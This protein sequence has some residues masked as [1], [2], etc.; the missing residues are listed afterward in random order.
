MGRERW[1]GDRKGRKRK[2]KKKGRRSSHGSVG[3]STHGEERRKG[4]E[5]KGLAQQK[6]EVGSDF[7]TRKKGKSV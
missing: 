3:F 2:K 1:G 6:G 4:R 5:S 7:A